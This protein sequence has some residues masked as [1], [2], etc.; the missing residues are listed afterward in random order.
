[1]YYIDNDDIHEY[2]CYDDVT[3]ETEYR[4]KGELS[5][6]DLT[7]C[8]WR[9][10]EDL[11]QQNWEDTMAEFVEAMIAKFP[12]LTR[13]DKWIEHDR[14]ALLEN[15]LFYIATA[16][17]EWSMAV[18]LIQKEHW[19]NN[20]DGLQKRHYQNYLDGI[21]ASLFEQFET[22]G[23]YAGAWTSGRISRSEILKGGVKSA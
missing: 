12:S 18:M 14:H 19:C 11:S 8:H 6:E 9:Y 4:K 3:G 15:K 23:T 20:L 5:Y 2:R 7:G 13:C 1:M 16:D 17:N 21:L 22:I 10:D